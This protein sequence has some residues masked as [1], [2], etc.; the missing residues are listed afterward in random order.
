MSNTFPE[1]VFRQPQDS[2]L[3]INNSFP[4]FTKCFRITM[5]TFVPSGWLWLAAPVHLHY[6]MRHKPR[7]NVPPSTLNVT[8]IVSFLVLLHILL[9]V[10]RLLSFCDDWSKFLC[11]VLLPLSLAEGIL[12]VLDYTQDI[13][14]PVLYADITVKGLTY[15]EKSTRSI[16]VVFCVLFTVLV[17][18]FLL[19]CWAES[20]PKLMTDKDYYVTVRYKYLLSATQP[21]TDP[22]A[23]DLWDLPPQYKCAS[24]IPKFLKIFDKSQHHLS[25]IYKKAVLKSEPKKEKTI[26]AVAL[27]EKESLL[28]RRTREASGPASDVTKPVPLLLSLVKTFHAQLLYANVL[29]LVGDCIQFANPA[30]LSILIDYMEHKEQYRQWHGY[31]L[32][33]AFFLVTFLVSVCQNQN[34]Y[35]SNNTG[36]KIKT[37]LVANVYR[38]ALS[39]SNETRRQ[40]TTGSIVNLMAIDCQ[41]I[42]TVTAQLWN[43]TSAPVQISLAFYF[44]YRQ[45]GMSFLVGVAI[46]LALIPINARIAIIAQRYQA[47]SWCSRTSV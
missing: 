34:F 35:H 11:F 24:V 8:K 6:V 45:L 38:K 32:V 27:S 44:L 4:E 15:G 30:L 3:L 40:F 18:Q 5:V 7:V 26:E 33:A 29:R 41:K 46:I 2:N 37:A 14:P 36:M 16:F 12:S 21:R 13:L 1:C 20:V 42:Q 47:V 31:G 43:L 9:S 28:Q 19:N 25:S 22:D 39:I 10:Y 17:L 23:A